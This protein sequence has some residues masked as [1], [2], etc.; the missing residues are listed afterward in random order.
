[1]LAGVKDMGG[2]LPVAIQEASHPLASLFPPEVLPLEL[3]ADL[4]S[5]MFALGDAKRT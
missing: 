1:M 4:S 5:I 3:H 2:S